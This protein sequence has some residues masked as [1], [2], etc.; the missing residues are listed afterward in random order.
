MLGVILQI[1]T[2]KTYIQILPPDTSAD[3]HIRI[4][5]AA[6]MSNQPLDWSSKPGQTK[7][8][9]DFLLRDKFINSL[10]DRVPEELPIRV[11]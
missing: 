11:D 2:S 4:L 1:F 7:S 5:P 8:A 3:R 6:Y 9:R 10:C